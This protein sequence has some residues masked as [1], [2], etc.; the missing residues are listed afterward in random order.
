MT[1]AALAF[2]WG[3]VCLHVALDGR[4]GRGRLV[5]LGVGVPVA[6]WG[7]HDIYTRGI[8]GGDLLY[9]VVALI[10]AVPAAL[11]RRRRTETRE[12]PADQA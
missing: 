10:A 6:A 7:A 11:S 5:L 1:I 4:A 9:L 12:P 8:G 3:T 2:A